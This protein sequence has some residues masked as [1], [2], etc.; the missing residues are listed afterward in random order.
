MTVERILHI[1]RE[2]C[3]DLVKLMESQDKERL[4]ALHQKLQEVEARR[5]AP[6]KS[7]HSGK[8]MAYAGLGYR[9]VIEM[10]AGIGIGAAMGYGLD[11]LFGTRPW[12]LVVMSLF[13]FAAGV[14]VMMA[15]ARE[16]DAKRKREEENGS[17]RQ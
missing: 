15:S 4:E 6:A 9:M 7:S 17:S 3:H 11:Y 8:H 5:A 13:G 16:F 12:F 2:I 1:L 14:K 10:A